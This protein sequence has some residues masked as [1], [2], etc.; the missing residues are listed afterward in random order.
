MATNK[1]I[2]FMRSTLE[3]GQ[4]DIEKL[5]ARKAS[6][7]LTPLE[8]RQL[9]ALIKSNEQLASRIDE[10]VENADRDDRAAE[11]RKNLIYGGAKVRDAGIYR[12]DN[13]HELSY[14]RDLYNKQRGDFNA[15]ERLH[16]NNAHVMESRA[17]ST[18]ATDGGEFAPPLWLTN[19]YAEFAR[20]RRPWLDYLNA[21]PL[22]S[23]QSSINVPKVTNGATVAVHVEN[24]LVSNND[25]VTAAVSSGIVTVAGA[26]T[27][28]LQL[29]TQSG[30]PIDQVI[31]RDLS[32]A[33][34]A[35]ADAQFLTGSGAGGNLRGA[36]TVATLQTFT[37]TNPGGA[38]VITEILKAA[39]TIS[40]TRFEW[41]NVIVMHPRRWVHLVNA[42]DTQGRPIIG[43]EEGGRN[44]QGVS[45]ESRADGIVGTIYGI[46]VLIDANVP[47]NLGAG[48][49]QDQIL[50]AVS[51]DVMAW[52]SPVRAEAF[53]STL[54][55][56]AQVYFRLLNFNA[57]IPDRDTK[58]LVK[59]DGTG[60]T[61]PTLT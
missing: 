33:H 61:P 57:S 51:E 58:G 22:P 52:E 47:T 25:M 24:G 4:V 8:K 46:P 17:L 30:T 35:L 43:V 44:V 37:A 29:L 56:L 40:T 34:G 11:V 48:T 16:R 55:D 36:L 38:A 60:L 7:T 2:E 12:Q 5:N 10:A 53:D 13:A 32:K 39:Q 26:Q 28:S 59:I 21:D 49:N 18:A 50:V 9:E 20:A 3:L 15:I 45:L 1:Q 31:F 27:V 6:G 42:K 23:G 54:A 41:P 14:F 19:R